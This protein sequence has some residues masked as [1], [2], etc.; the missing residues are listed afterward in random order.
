MT[1]LG[2]LD[3]DAVSARAQEALL[4]LDR[5]FVGTSDYMG[6]AWFWSIT[7][8]NLLRARSPAA[9]RRAHQALLCAGLRVNGSS[10]AHR[11]TITRALGST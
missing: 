3:A 1:R 10:R 6:L 7:Y 2:H 4:R 11:N 9:R 5:E 8:A